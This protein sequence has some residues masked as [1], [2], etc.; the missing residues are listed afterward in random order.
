ME[1]QQ[2]IER[3]EACVKVLNGTEFV[4]FYSKLKTMFEQEGGWIFR[5]E[6]MNSY[7][8]E[9]VENDCDGKQIE[10]DK[11]DA[12]LNSAKEFT[13]SI[14][15]ALCDAYYADKCQPIGD[16]EIKASEKSQRVIWAIKCT[17]LI[18]KVRDQFKAKITDAD[19]EFCERQK[20]DSIIQGNKHNVRL[21]K[22]VV[23][24]P[25]YDYGCGIGAEE[26]RWL[27]IPYTTYSF[28]ENLAA[29]LNINQYRLE[30]CMDNSLTG[31]TALR[32]DEF[33]CSPKATYVVVKIVFFDEMRSVVDK[34]LNKNNL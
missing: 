28:M 7:E 11:G 6:N 4:N 29:A 34:Y 33:A 9:K 20:E 15:D 16:Y 3:R 30:D 8:V 19:D 31:R 18:R 26:K 12:I 17:A 24:V 5:G 22:G 25:L 21:S 1:Q 32:L 27:L 10:E 13:S 2:E 23:P 14:D